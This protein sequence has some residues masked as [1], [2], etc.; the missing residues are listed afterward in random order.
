[1]FI[2][3]YKI[4]T[5]FKWA[6]FRAHLCTFA[7][8]V[9]YGSTWRAPRNA[10]RYGGLMYGL[11]LTVAMVVV[12]LPTT[13]LQL[14]LGQLSQQ[15]AVGVWSAVPFFK[16]VGYLRLLISMLE[17][18]HTIVYVALTVTYF[19]YTLSNS[20]PFWECQYVV[21][22]DD[23]DTYIVNATSC[24]NETFLAPVSE[25]PE[26]YVALAMIV[27]VL[28]ILFP[29]VLF[30]P[31][32][33]MK[34]I[35][36]LIGP[37][38]LILCIVILS[39]VGDRS[40][41]IS[42]YDHD[43]LQ[44]LIMPSFWH[45]AVIQALLATQTTNGYLIL[46]GDT[47]YSR[48]NVQWTALIFVGVNV[49]AAWAGVMFWYAISGSEG[50]D[51]SSVAV[52]I[53]TYRVAVEKNLS[54]AWPLLI[55]LMLFLSGIVTVLTL[56]YPI[57]DHCR[58]V[59]GS[60]WRYVAVASSMASVAG[61][62]AATAGGLSAFGAIEDVA[63]PLLISLTTVIEISAFVLIYGWKT[64]VEDVEFLIEQA[65][66]KYWVVGWFAA[67]CIITT[68]ATWWTVASLI[69]NAK[70]TE[71]PWEAVVL[72]STA[73]VAFSIFTIFAV[74]SVAKQVQ[75]DAVAKLQSSFK[76]SRH[77]GPRDP[78]T[79]YYWLARRDESERNFPRT[80]YR[81]HLGQFSGNASFLHVSDARTKENPVENKRRAN[82]DDW[83]Y[84][85]CRKKYLEQIYPQYM[86]ENKQ[87][88]KSLDWSLFSNFKTKH[89]ANVLR[90]PKVSVVTSELALPGQ[91]TNNN[92]TK[93]VQNVCIR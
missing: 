56:L 43:D 75:Y 57:Y 63:V 32:K 68:F 48:T 80:R 76:P 87:R 84:T 62:L 31:L 14:A 5:W 86:K 8:A 81:R 16:G 74:V 54:T 39:S 9:S 25:K 17:V 72:V 42:F 53:E 7:V 85:V 34:R 36:Y 69:D 79:H 67:P 52:L 3:S 29:F 21:V 38:V 15:N 60:K 45:G 61:A 35:F 83:L 19:M 41:F 73:G 27:V 82:S 23:N 30:S 26:Y 18:V 12:A 6:P 33:L 44:H 78:I 91:E 13:M 20:I 24:F 10:F 64:L 37:T 65:M 1:M 40:N 28:S 77:W 2:N 11:T 88:S 22:P 90:I 70:W 66:S 4:K 51:T 92:V 89:T 46:A 59:G 93:Q 50:S 58:R 49:V 47:F 71:S 55:F